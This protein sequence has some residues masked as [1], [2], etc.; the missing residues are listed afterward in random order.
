MLGS[1]EKKEI[2]FLDEGKISQKVYDSKWID[3]YGNYSKDY[4]LAR[5]NYNKEKVITN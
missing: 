2:L 3:N 5:I 1:Y 4:C